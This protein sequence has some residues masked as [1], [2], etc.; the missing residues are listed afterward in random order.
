MSPEFREINLDKVYISPLNVRRDPGDLSKIT[1]SVKDVGVLE[2]ILVRQRGEEYEAIAG[3][4][5]V[6]AARHAG[7]TTIPAIVLEVTDLE[8]I[9]I[10][11]T[12]NIQRKDLTLEERMQ[13]Y[14]ALQLL[15]PEYNNLHSL[16]KV[17]GLSHQ[18]ISQDFQ[19]W[20]M[21]GKLLPYGIRVASYLPPSHEERQR[22]TA[23]PEYHAVMLHQ[24]SDALKE[25]SAAPD[26]V[27]DAQIAELAR[28]IAPHSQEEAK[29]IIAYVKSAEDYFD[30]LISQQEAGAIISPRR[31]SSHR[32]GVSRQ[33][34][35]AA[36]WGQDGGVVT[37]AFCVQEL[38]LI[39]A[40]DGM[41]QLIRQSLR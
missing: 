29:E 2:P 27:F 21:E 8:V 1:D 40:E 24:A 9:L 10:S 20:E 23:L 32:H 35:P 31:K 7:H 25:T 30:K 5:R 11:L 4:R 34:K 12:E 38:T 26:D 16:A 19:A 28:Q 3:S 36:M 22:G 14:Q 37:C 15:D 41:H 18:K 6:Q 17:A 33:S 39:H 13:T